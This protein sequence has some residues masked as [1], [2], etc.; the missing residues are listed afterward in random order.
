MLLRIVLSVAL[1]GGIGLAIGLIGKSMGGQCPLACNPYV[2]TGLGVIIGLIIASRSDAVGAQVQSPNVVRLASD[3]Q[4][5]EVVSQA[6]GPVLVEF[7]TSSCPYCVK[8]MPAINSLAD[9]YAGRATV[10]VAN[11]RTLRET[12]AEQ[13]VTAVPTA[14][15]MSGGQVVEVSHGLKSEKDLAAMLERHLQG[16]GPAGDPPPPHAG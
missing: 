7:Y 2:S 5:R 6:R 1:G 4:F 16:E 13:S 12:A 14:L 11:A 9:R 3:A 10:A 15:V 8:Q